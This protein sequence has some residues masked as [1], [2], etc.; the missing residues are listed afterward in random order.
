V[1]LHEITIPLFSS[2]LI[3]L[4]WLRNFLDNSVLGLLH[5]VDVC[6]VLE[7]HVALVFRFEDEAACIFKTLVTLHI[8][9]SV[10]AQEQN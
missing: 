9:H 5:S 6:D 10:T 1:T 3:L 8:Y 2:N 7:V 4:P